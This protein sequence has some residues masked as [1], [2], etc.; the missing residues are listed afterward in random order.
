MFEFRS[1][2]K[3]TYKQLKTKQGV[4]FVLL[5]LL[6]S[7]MS[8]L[9]SGMFYDVIPLQLR[10][11]L[12]DNY[13]VYVLSYF[14]FLIFL[15]LIGGRV[16]FNIILLI[17]SVICALYIPVGLSWGVIN[18]GLISSFLGTRVSMGV[19]YLSAL[20]KTSFVIQ[21]AYVILAIVL[22]LFSKKIFK[23]HKN[24]IFQNIFYLLII[25]LCFIIANHVHIS[26]KYMNIVIILSLLVSALLFLFYKVRFELKSDD[27][28]Y[29]FKMNKN[30]SDNKEM[31][32]L[33]SKLMFLIF[34][35]C[36]LFKISYSSYKRNFYGNLEAGSYR[37]FKEKKYMNLLKDSNNWEVLEKNKKHK[38]KNYVLVLGESVRPDYMHLYGYPVPNTPFLDSVNGTFMEHYYAAGAYTNVA[39]TK[40]LYYFQDPANVESVFGNV[41][42]LAKQAGFNT[43]WLSNAHNAW[44]SDIITLQFQANE[45]VI[46]GVIQ[47]DD[48]LLVQMSKFMEK[49]K[50]SDK[51]N[52]FILHTL[53]SHLNYCQRLK[54][55]PRWQMK[56]NTD[57]D[58]YLQSI[59]QTD[60]WLKEMTERLAKHGSYSVLYFSDHGVAHGKPSSD[61]VNLHHNHKWV[62]NF[63]VPLVVINSDDKEHKIIKA[64]KSAFNFAYG[65]SEWLDIKEKHFNSDYCFFCENPDETIRME[66]GDGL[67]NVEILFKDP[68]IMPDEVDRQIYWEP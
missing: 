37:Y 52:L 50:S 38:Y 21:A 6:Y 61:F 47:S 19:E 65:F 43:V 36:S 60:Q 59:Y 18:K 24:H 64:R 10:T 62:S 33:F 63:H 11:H 27:E 55:K 48:D 22:Y 42:Q 25:L 20:P 32:L 44:I 57:I 56:I 54:E 29:R 17:N 46:N 31:L 49:N 41:V 30:K 7:F 23:T 39:L 15:L 26:S 68:A 3:D 12:Y 16:L 13:I 8:I 35:S 58:C 5:V 28:E 34:I 45:R 40:S 4:I 9:A 67:V 1:Y 14:I 66:A 2:F 53:G 51:P